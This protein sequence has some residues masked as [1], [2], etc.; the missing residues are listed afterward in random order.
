[1]NTNQL[2]NVTRKNVFDMSS[3]MSLWHA[4]KR[5]VLDLLTH[6]LFVKAVVDPRVG[7]G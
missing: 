5:H 2:K 7:L 6:S 4:K 3:E 1:M